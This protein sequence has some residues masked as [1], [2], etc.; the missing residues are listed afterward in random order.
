MFAGWA[1]WARYALSKWMEEIE[2]SATCPFL[3]SVEK[4]NYLLRDFD[5]SEAALFVFLDDL[6]NRNQM[7]DAY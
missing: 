3:G 5:I 7:P 4:L 1:A 6:E 2:E